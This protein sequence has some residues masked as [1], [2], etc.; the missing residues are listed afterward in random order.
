MTEKKS[1]PEEMF[2]RRVARYRQKSRTM[3]PWQEVAETAL[4]VNSL[5][6]RNA[7]RLKFPDDFLMEREDA[8]GGRR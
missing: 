8:P 3:Q 6:H 1:Y 7:L 2:E 4:R 5:V